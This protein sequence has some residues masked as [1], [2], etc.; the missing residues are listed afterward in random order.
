ML[1]R[2]WDRFQIFAGS[3]NFLLQVM[4]GGGAGCISA[5]ANVNPAAINKLYREWQEGGAAEQQRMLDELRA[6]VQSFPM[7]P[8]LKAITAHFSGDSQWRRVRPP[9]LDLPDEQ[10]DQLIARLSEAE[11]SMPGLS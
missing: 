4:R 7:I 5:T 2:N 10:C 9:L 3:E 1:E 11:F 8:A 6:I